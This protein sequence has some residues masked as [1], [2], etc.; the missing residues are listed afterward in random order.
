MKEIV[1]DWSLNLIHKTQSLSESDAQKVPKS[2]A[3][4][5]ERY[6]DYYFFDPL[7]QY[8][9]D[10][11]NYEDWE[12]KFS[13]ELI[14][15]DE[16]GNRD[17]LGSIFFLVNGIQEYSAPSE[18]FDNLGR[19]KFE[20]S[21]QEKKGTVETNS[22][23]LIIEKFLLLFDVKPSAQKTRVFVSH[24]IDSIHGSLLQDGF[25]LAKNLK[26]GT[27]AKHITRQLLK[28]PDWLNMD[29]IQKLNTE[30][31]IRSTFFWLTQKGM[32]EDAVMNADYH[33]QK[34][35]RTLEKVKDNDNISGLHKASTKLS[36]DEEYVDELSP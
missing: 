14:L 28:S 36:I 17:F 23:Q 16:K 8:L 26:V 9:S 33:V 31:G 5:L 27:L 21:I 6:P 10:L 24:D 13:Q 34:I 32:G 3:H 29:Q 12:T 15:T 4:L 30:H 20:G 35:T 22:V 7:Y 11:E 2:M 19:F 1:V 25:Y 18:R